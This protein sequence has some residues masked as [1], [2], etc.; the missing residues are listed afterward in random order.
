MKH[1]FNYHNENG[2]NYPD[3]ALPE[4]EHTILGNMD[5]MHLDFLK[6]YRRGTYTTL[7]SECKLNERLHKI[8]IEAH[9]LLEDYTL[10]I[11]KKIGYY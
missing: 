7:L 6:K 4:Q 1:E 2:F 5:L 8:N 10:K 11:V 9:S 3:L